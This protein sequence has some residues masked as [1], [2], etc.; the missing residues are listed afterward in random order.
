MRTK[1][2]EDTEEKNLSYVSLGNPQESFG[3]GNSLIS[4]PT[5]LDILVRQ[6]STVAMASILLSLFTPNNSALS[7]Q[8]PPLHNC[9]QAYALVVRDRLSLKAGCLPRSILAPQGHVAI[10]SGGL[11]SI[12]KLLEESYDI[13]SLGAD[14]DLSCMCWL[15][16]DIRISISCSIQ[17]STMLSY[18]NDSCG[19]GGRGLF[20]RSFSIVVLKSIINVVESKAILQKRNESRTMYF[21]MIIDAYMIF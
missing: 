21:E 3:S 8:S 11:L 1:E 7:R 2:G 5:H 10:N 17:K 4:K 19:V 6:K 9:P 14:A 13:E 18:F 20:S 16:R 12:G 15:L